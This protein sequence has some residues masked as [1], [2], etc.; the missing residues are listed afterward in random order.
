MVSPLLSL[1]TT[2]PLLAE[3]VAE[4]PYCY[5][6]RVLG[7]QVG[8]Q[9]ELN[10]K[11]GRHSDQQ[12]GDGYHMKRP[13]CMLTYFRSP[14]QRHVEKPTWPALSFRENCAKHR[15][16]PED[17]RLDIEPRWSLE[18][19][20]A[21]PCGISAPGDTEIHAIQLSN[22]WHDLWDGRTPEE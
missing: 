2:E 17:M 6:T 12:E 4:G 14:S 15:K 3:F 20:S 19:D 11:A 13:R 5:Y 21:I 16:L 18:A 9:T 8:L 10:F 7:K 1:S 22:D